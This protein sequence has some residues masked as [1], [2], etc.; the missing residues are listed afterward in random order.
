MILFIIEVICFFISVFE[1]Y[2]MPQSY[3]ITAIFLQVSLAVAL[4]LHFSQ[5]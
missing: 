4:Q 1:C 5:T 3:L 2:V